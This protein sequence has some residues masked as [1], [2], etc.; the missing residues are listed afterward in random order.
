MKIDG[1]KI[2][3]E[4]YKDLNLRILK[5]RQQGLNLQIIVVIIGADPASISYITQKRKRCEEI[6]I[7]FTLL[8]LPLNANNKELADI[9]NKYNNNPAVHGIII[10][11]PVPPQID[12]QILTNTIN[13][14]KDID[15]F[16]ADSAFEVPVAKAVIR[17]LEEVYLAHN[18][19][20]LRQNFKVINEQSDYGFI[21]WLKTK[22]IAILGR[23]E[24]AGTPIIKHLYKT[25]LNPLIITSTT[26]NPEKIIKSSDIVISAVGKSDIIKP[27]YLKNDVI[28]LGVGMHKGTDG[29]FHGDYNPDE[30]ISKASF[31]TPVTGG[32]GP[33]NVAYL[34][35]NLVISAERTV[36]ISNK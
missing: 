35:T 7:K 17:V 30:I 33:I 34:I 18:N 20:D 32:I 14:N 1:I 31:Y 8:K 27:E 29:K 26:I 21:K 6:G 24:T 28:L 3:D 23:G 11:R 36:N 16:R 9:I 10:Q 22:S 2:A 13:T 4:I 19:N 12:K 5:L 25:G 15:G